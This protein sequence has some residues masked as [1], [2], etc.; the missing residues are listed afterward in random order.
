MPNFRR[1][2]VELDVVHGDDVLAV[3]PDVAGVGLE[4][5]HEVLHQH[6]LALPRAADDD[7]DLAALDVEIDALQHLVRAEA[8]LDAADADLVVLATLGER[9][10]DRRLRSFVLQHQDDVGEE[11]VED[12]DGHEAAD[13][14]AG[15]ADADAL[16]AARG[17]EALRAG[18]RAPAR[19]RRP[20]P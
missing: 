15:G 6:R 18:D 20:W 8:L 7:V 12:Q 19:S 2:L 16:G 3:D 10:L 5:A 1:T 13:D 9:S 17:V 11:V 14:R 4:Q